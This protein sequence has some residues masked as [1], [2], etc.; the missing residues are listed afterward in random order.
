MCFFPARKAQDVRWEV[1]DTTACSSR[2]VQFGRR[3]ER[4][5]KC[6]CHHRMDHLN[7]IYG[8]NH[9]EVEGIDNAPVIICHLSIGITTVTVIKI[10]IINSLNSVHTK[11]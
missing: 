6:S 1:V 10:I 7:I 3:R 9:N 4:D 8:K 11:K 2:P 5:K